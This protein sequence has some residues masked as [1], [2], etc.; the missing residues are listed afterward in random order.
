MNGFISFFFSHV[1]VN[2]IPDIVI[3]LM[4]IIALE[5]YFKT[6][7]ENGGDSTVMSINDVIHSGRPRNMLTKIK[8]TLHQI[9]IYG[10]F[11]L[12]KQVVCVHTSSRKRIGLFP[13]IL[14]S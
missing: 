6:E 8:I 14:H 5:S 13:Y 11:F 3:S 10:F 12:S 2:E 9:S 7:H 4:P 1:S